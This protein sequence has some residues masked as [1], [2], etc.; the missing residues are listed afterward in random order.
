[1]RQ[2]GLRAEERERASEEKRA[3]E[4]AAWRREEQVLREALDAAAADQRALYASALRS[5][6]SAA[7]RPS[8][9]PAQLTQSASGGIGGSG[10]GSRSGGGVSSGEDL[11]VL[12]RRL[13]AEHDGV[14]R[15]LKLTHEAEMRRIGTFCTFSRNSWRTSLHLYLMFFFSLSFPL[16][17]F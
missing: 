5:A 17:L 8:P 4:R 15:A 11:M 7:S 2:L 6:A 14:I 12:E 10:G 16:V 3:A 9:S 13:R 1:V